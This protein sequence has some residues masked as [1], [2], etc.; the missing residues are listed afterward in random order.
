MELPLSMRCPCWFKHKPRPCP[1]R[2]IS[3]SLPAALA[4]YA[5]V[6][7]EQLG[8]LGTDDDFVDSDEEEYDAPTEAL[9]E[10]A[11]NRYDAVLAALA[12]WQNRSTRGMCCMKLAR[13]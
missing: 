5:A 3:G 1:A 6:E 9:K 4:I 10:A 11:Y 7:C 12:A 8:V 2:N 13:G